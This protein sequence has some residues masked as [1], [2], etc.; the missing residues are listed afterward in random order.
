[1]ILAIQGGMI[2]RAGRTA[3][4]AVRIVHWTA[5]TMFVEVTGAEH[6]L[7]AYCFVGY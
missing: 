5:G 7:H 6:R 3:G 2:P 1:M 4:T